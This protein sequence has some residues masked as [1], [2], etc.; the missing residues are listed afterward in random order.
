YDDT[1]YPCP[2][3]P[4]YRNLL[5]SP[6]SVQRLVL[7]CLGG[8]DC[9]NGPKSLFFPNKIFL[10]IPVFLRSQLFP[11]FA[12][13]RFSA[14][15]LFSYTYRHACSVGGLDSVSCPKR[16]DFSCQNRNKDSSLGLFSILFS[17]NCL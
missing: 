5:F 1:G 14:M 4:E 11:F 16:F 8:F 15:A 2:K 13:A 7:F 10:D 12:L 6:F 3:T 9:R 17:R